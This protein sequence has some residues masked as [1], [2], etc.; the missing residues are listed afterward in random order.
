M[1]RY[2]WHIT[3]V[4]K[5]VALQRPDHAEPLTAWLVAARQLAE[6]LAAAH[7]CTSQQKMHRVIRYAC[8]TFMMR[9]STVN[10]GLR[11]TLNSATAI[12]M[13]RTT[14]EIG[15]NLQAI[16]LLGARKAR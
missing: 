4:C 10:P 9:C 3:E 16:L 15:K 11:A 8:A 2:A 14:K 6:G 7:G 13:A 12:R 5:P 1:C